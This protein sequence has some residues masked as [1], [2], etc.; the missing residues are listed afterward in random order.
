MLTRSMALLLVLACTSGCSLFE[1]LGCAPHCKSQARNSSSLVGFLY[2]GN[3][4]P[5]P[6]DTIPE[7]HVPLRVGLAFLPSQVGGTD[8]QLDPAH[9]EQILERIKSRFSSRP[10]VRE[11]IIIPEYYLAGQSGMEG[12]KGVQRLYNIDIMALVS[13]DQ[14]TYSD[15]NR[16]SLSYLTIVGAYLVNGTVHDTTTLVDLAVVDPQSRSLILRAGGTDTR[17]QS[18]TLINAGEK[19]RSA[20]NQGFD[21]AAAQMIEHFDQALIAF[22]TAVHEGKANVKVVSREPKGSSGGGGTAL[23]ATDIAGLL[24]LLM[25]GVVMRR[26]SRQN[27]A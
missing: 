1:R 25:L 23:D 4:T 17:H 12:L 8:A 21:A 18:S 27:A 16:L 24:V 6:Q 15:D 2:P 22:E 13:Y 26:P 11:I 3:E 10:F 20:S 7:L 19:V 5:P 9:K 14:V